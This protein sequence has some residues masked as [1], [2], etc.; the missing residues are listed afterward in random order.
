MSAQFPAFVVD[1]GAGED[2]TIFS[3]VHC[4]KNSARGRAQLYCAKY[5]HP[6]QISHA[7]YFIDTQEDFDKRIAKRSIETVQAKVWRIENELAHAKN[8]LRKAH[9]KRWALE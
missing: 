9:E 3:L 1:V 2:Y 4:D 8:E 5:L 7:V 6:K